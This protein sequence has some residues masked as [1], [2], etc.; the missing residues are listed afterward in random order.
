MKP[1]TIESLPDA[2]DNMRYGSSAVIG[3]KAYFKSGASKTVLELSKNHW[4]E[5]PPCP[6]TYFAIV[7]IDEMLTTVGGRSDTQRYSNKLYTATIATNGLN[8]SLPCQLDD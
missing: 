3:D 2:P 8:T 1:I 5:L 6:N 4:H 7:C